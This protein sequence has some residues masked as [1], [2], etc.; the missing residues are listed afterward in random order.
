MNEFDYSNI[1]SLN[2]N[3]NGPR[4]NSTTHSVIVSHDPKSPSK[5]KI[6]MIPIYNEPEISSVGDAIK[7]LEKFK[8]KK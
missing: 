2:L 1:R 6:K 7:L 8:L 4:W 5:F 3:F